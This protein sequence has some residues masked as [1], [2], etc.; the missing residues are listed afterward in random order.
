MKQRIAGFVTFLNSCTEAK[1]NINFPINFI[2]YLFT[3]IYKSIKLVIEQKKKI[4]EA[5]FFLRG[6]FT[7]LFYFFIFSEYKKKML[8]C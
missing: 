4:Q 6:N 1:L 7:S 3:S 8:L 2:L 5:C